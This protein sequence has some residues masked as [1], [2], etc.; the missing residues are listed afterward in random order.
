M[1][2][3]QTSAG[4]KDETANQRHRDDGPAGARKNDKSPRKDRA[5]RHDVVDRAGKDL[6]RP[7]SASAKASAAPS[8]KGKFTVFA[9]YVKSGWPLTW[10]TWKRQGI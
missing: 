4:A 9:A 3:Q 2:G 6:G 7:N 8:K 10:K 1:E 5:D